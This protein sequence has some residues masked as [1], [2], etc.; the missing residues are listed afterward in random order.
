VETILTIS[1]THP[2]TYV[3][4]PVKINQVSTFKYL[5]NA[6]LK[7]LKPHN[8]P[9]PVYK[10]LPHGFA[11]FSKY[12]SDVAQNIMSATYK[13]LIGGWMGWTMG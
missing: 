12:F 3:T 9:V 8:S 11:G 13:G 6:N 4:R 2:F 7:Y 5:R 10:Y 1:L